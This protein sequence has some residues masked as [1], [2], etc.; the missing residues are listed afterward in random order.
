[1]TDL[2]R[3]FCRTP[4]PAHLSGAIAQR[5]A[6]T[7]GS[8]PLLPRARAASSHACGASPPSSRS[9]P[10]RSPPAGRRAPGWK[11]LPRG[12]APP[13]HPCIGLDELR[14]AL[15]VRVATRAVGTAR[16]QSLQARRSHAACGRERAR[17]AGVDRAPDTAGAARREADGVARL[18]H[19][20]ANAVDP[21]AR[22]SASYERELRLVVIVAACIVTRTAPPCAR[23]N[24]QW[25]A[26]C[27][28]RDEAA[29]SVD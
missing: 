26:R 15:L 1:M 20:A 19:A 16:L 11:E 29:Q 21:A 2:A 12:G 10:T 6:G 18:V 17:P 7:A 25:R 13:E 27:R 3:A 24:L 14:R 8:V 23:R 4:P 22:T 28:N 5:G 9:R